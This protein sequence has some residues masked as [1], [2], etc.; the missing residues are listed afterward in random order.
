MFDTN[1]LSNFHASDIMN[2]A[3]DIEMEKANI[4]S[5]EIKKQ[6]LSKYEHRLHDSNF[7]DI[8]KYL[9]LDNSNTFIR[10]ILPINIMFLKNNGFRVW[11]LNIWF[12]EKRPFEFDGPKTY[13]YISWGEDME[14]RMKSTVESY[15]NNV[16]KYE[17]SEL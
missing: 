13:Q 15:G 10:E 5:K 2:I 4:Q 9:R 8:E 11:N 14:K 16:L 12:K 6:I 1:E 3:K 17:Y 7:N